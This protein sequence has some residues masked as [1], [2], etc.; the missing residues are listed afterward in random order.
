MIPISIQAHLH[1]R[2]Y[3]KKKGMVIIMMSKNYVMD[4]KNTNAYLENAL[5]DVLKKS[6]F[7]TE[8]LFADSVK[9]RCYSV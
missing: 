5:F 4:N 3:K 6:A 9:R 8:D 1:Y 2:R 7:G